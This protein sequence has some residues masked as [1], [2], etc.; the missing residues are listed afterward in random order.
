MKQNTKLI[1]PELLEYYLDPNFEIIAE[2]IVAG[3]EE[4]E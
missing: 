2:A 1:F 4:R 3:F